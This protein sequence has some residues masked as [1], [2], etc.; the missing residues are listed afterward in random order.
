M[1]LLR[2]RTQINQRL[3]GIMKGICLNPNCLSYQTI[4]EVVKLGYDL[5]KITNQ[6]GLCYT[7]SAIEPICIDC[8]K[9][10]KIVFDTNGQKRSS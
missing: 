4:Y 6:D 2:E 3:S 9:E 7:I 10:L 8:A 1:F 5:W